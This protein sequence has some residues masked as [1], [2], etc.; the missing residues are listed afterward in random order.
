MKKVLIISLIFISLAYYFFTKLQRDIN[1]S[2]TWEMCSIHMEIDNRL[3]RIFYCFDLVPEYKN[4]IFFNQ[5]KSSHIEYACPSQRPFDKNLLLHLDETIDI[6]LTDALIEET[7]L[8]LDIYNDE[9]RL[10][11]LNEKKRV[12]RQNEFCA[13]WSETN[14]LTE[15]IELQPKKIEFEWPDEGKI[16]YIDQEE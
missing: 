14:A 7:N 2:V 3:D 5:N 12:K 15:E 1:T 10:E 9:Q 11:Y 13:D 4:T 6:N 8:F 16:L